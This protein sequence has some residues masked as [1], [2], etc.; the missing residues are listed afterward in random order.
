VIL[1]TGG[2]E[3]RKTGRQEDKRSKTARARALAVWQSGHILYD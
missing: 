2:Q 3:D 1:L